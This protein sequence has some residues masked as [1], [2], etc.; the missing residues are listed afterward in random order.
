MLLETTKLTGVVAS[1]GQSV[2]THI[3]LQLTE[4]VLPMQVFTHFERR[5]KDF[6]AQQTAKLHHFSNLV[7]FQELKTA[8]CKW[9]K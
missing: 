6:E 3:R 4:V 5:E 8:L 7:I 9:F 2:V 1:Q